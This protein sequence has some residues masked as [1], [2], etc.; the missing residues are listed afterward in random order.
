MNN[1]QKAVLFSAF[2]AVAAAS[3]APFAASKNVQPILIVLPLIFMGVFLCVAGYY[4]GLSRN[5]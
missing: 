5:K 3:S 2:A 4:A 1:R